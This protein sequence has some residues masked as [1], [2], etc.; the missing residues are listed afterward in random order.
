MQL[1]MEKPQLTIW[2]VEERVDA[3]EYRWQS[4]QY[5]HLIQCQFNAHS[6]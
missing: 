2:Q 3:A 1:V 4:F 6:D 5:E